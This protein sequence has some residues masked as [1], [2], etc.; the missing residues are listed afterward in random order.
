MTDDQMVS[1]VRADIVRVKEQIEW[2][3]KASIPCDEARAWVDEEVERL[4]IDGDFIRMVAAQ[5]VMPR[6]RRFM[7]LRE[8]LAGQEF[9]RNLNPLD[10][11]VSILASIFKEELK[12]NLLEGLDSHEYEAGLPQRERPQRLSELKA[13]L[14]EL[15]CREE[16]LIEDADKRGIEILRRAD[17]DP[18]VVLAYNPDGEWG[19]KE[20]IRFTPKMVGGPSLGNSSGVA[21]AGT[22]ASATRAA[23][24]AAPPFP[25]SPSAIGVH[26]RGAPSSGSDSS[27]P[28]LPAPGSFL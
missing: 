20:E 26:G 9:L 11:T 22:H 1:A 17:A 8:V 6:N 24:P 16:A 28:N 25:I 2:T 13:D 3:D 12:A 14:F 19:A 5:A 15:E 23:G 18:V 10:R 4:A 7:S 21:P 27:Q